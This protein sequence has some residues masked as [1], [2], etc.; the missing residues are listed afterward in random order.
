MKTSV[1]IKMINKA[2]EHEKSTN[3]LAKLIKKLTKQ[4]GKIISFE[5]AQGVSN[6][7]IKYVSLVPSYIEEGMAA[8]KKFGIQNEMSQMLRELEYYWT[9]DQDL[10]PDNLGLVGI[11]DDAY[12]SIYLLQVLSEYCSK[13]TNRPLLQLDI[14]APNKIIRSI[15]GESIA[16]TL[17]Q[18]VQLTIANNMSNQIFNQV[19]QNIFS[20]GFTFG[21][22]AQSYINQREI[23]DRVDVQLGAMGIF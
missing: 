17:E 5:E 8:S 16:V 10:I 22:A 9:L 4:N 18:K 13:I 11:V 23:E 2:V 3:S 14:D 6:F 21:N 7:V 19:Y 12:A 20:S 15:L 1:I